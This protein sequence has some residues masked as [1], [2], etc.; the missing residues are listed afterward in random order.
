MRIISL[1]LQLNKLSLIVFAFI[2]KT[3]KMYSRKSE[4]ISINMYIPTEDLII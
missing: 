4:Q 3:W 1:Q 2:H